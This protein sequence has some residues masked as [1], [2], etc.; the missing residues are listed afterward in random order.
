M[1]ASPLYG[2]GPARAASGSHGALVGASTPA[3]APA[4]T[5][6]STLASAGLCASREGAACSLGP[7]GVVGGIGEGLEEA[8]VALEVL[9]VSLDAEV[10]AVG[11]IL[12]RLD[13]AVVA[14]GRHEQPRC[15]PVDGL[16]VH[17][18]H[19]QKARAT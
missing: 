7:R 14:A 6:A 11:G 12:H 4:R 8:A 10:E 2:R 5:P 3:R 9:G 1:R 13:D 17:G 19:R 18:V 15:Q 16:M